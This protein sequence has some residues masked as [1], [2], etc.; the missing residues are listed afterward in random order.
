MKR[1]V[2]FSKFHGTGNDFIMVDD[3]LMAFPASE[4]YVSSLCNRRT[5]IG[6]DGLILIRPAVGFDFQ[7]VYFNSDGREGSM[8]GN[9]GR[10][11]AA[12]ALLLGLAGKQMR[13]LGVDGPHEATV[14]DD[15]S[16]RL[17][18]N[19]VTGID[20]RGD[21]LFVDTGSPHVVQPIEQ[22]SLVN[23]LERGAAIRNAAIHAPGGTNVNFVSVKGDE[24]HVRTFERGV[25]DETLSCGTGVTAAALVAH[26]SDWIS[27]DMRTVE[28][29]TPGGRL[30]VDFKPDGK[31]GYGDIWL[32]GP[33]VHVFDGI[34]AY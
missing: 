30:R 14:S 5:G 1:A 26:A 29:F 27:S 28:V 22:L 18:M 9:G 16:V 25:E 34:T 7:M 31:G 12:F 6:A 10:C 2:S 17:R 15:G 4:D 33:A 32:E 20:K 8:C 21:H 23:V 3:L 19:D 24:L 11:A 13:F